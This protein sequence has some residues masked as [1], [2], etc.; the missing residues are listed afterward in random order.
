MTRS[1]TQSITRLFPIPCMLVSS[2]FAQSLVSTYHN[3]KYRSGWAFQETTLTPSNVNSTSF[4]KL[5]IMPAD[6]KV[7]A[8]P[9]YVPGLNIAGATHNVVFVVTENDTVYAYD[10]D[11]SGSPLWQKSLLKAGETPSDSRSCSQIVPQIGITSTPAIDLA[12][13]PHALMYVIAMSKDTAG[14][15]Y[16][17]LHALDITTGVEQLGG[18]VTVTATYPG[19]GDGSANGTI[20]FDPAQYVERAALLITN[21]ALVT[22]WSSHC[23]NRPYTGFVI[24]YSTTTLRQLS[25][26]DVTPN[27]SE[28]SVWQSGSGPS[29]DTAGN[30]Y[31]LQAN[32]TFDTNLN[33]AGFPN[34]GDFG[35]SFMKLSNSNYH[36]AVADYFTMFN[37]VQESN[38]DTDLGSGGAMLLPDLKDAAGKTRSLAVGA[39][40]DSNIYVVDRTNLGKFNPT[41]NNN[42]QELDGAVHGGAWSSPAYFFHTVYFGGVGDYIRSFAFA[43][44]KFSL[45]SQTTHQFGYPGA[46][47]S[48]SSSGLSNA[49]LWATENTSPAILHA[50]DASNLATEY[51]NS[52]QAGS[53]DNFGNGNKFITPMIANGKVYV[54]TQ[55]GVGV[56]G[57]LTG[58]VAKLSARK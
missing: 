54:G 43:N 15:Y 19:T 24:T 57:L 3:D 52:S 16:Q 23:D 5:F 47:P 21:G 31:F 49:I 11:V 7:D 48:V 53:R 55:D 36:L 33:A 13:K 6:G 12:I 45:S 29:A 37:T 26:L 42:Y 34:E 8:E 22:S 44:G 50:Y 25:V 46:T 35:N 14:K 51:Y 4:G 18:P 39:G 9:L 38:T 58:Q 40:K 1:M 17:R 30:I 27:G 2:V 56:L 41:T 28:G 32:G 20:T 10:A